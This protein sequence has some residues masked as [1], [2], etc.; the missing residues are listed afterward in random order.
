MLDFYD[1]VWPA[2]LRSYAHAM[3]TSSLSSREKAGTLVCG[4]EY[5]RD[6]YLSIP[7]AQPYT[8]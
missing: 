5:Q 3:Y 1:H 7:Q 2:E 6:M 4:V 8:S